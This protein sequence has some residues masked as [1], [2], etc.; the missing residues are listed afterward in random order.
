MALKSKG[1]YFSLDAL[2][3]LM[4]LSAMLGLV[5]QT[6]AIESTGPTVN[7]GV[8]S[9]ENMLKQPV[10]DF[11][12]S[13]NYSEKDDSVAV[14]VRNSYEEGDID[15]SEEIAGQYLEQLGHEAAL[16]LTNET[17]STLVYNTSSMQNSKEI[18]SQM[19]YLPYTDNSE[20]RYNTARMVIWN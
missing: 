10:G 14:A 18:R 19:V 4:I 5:F 12:E 11:N 20:T 17:D 6:Y 15:K 1:F 9:L 16:Y 7:K 3:A 8:N 13:I 2:M